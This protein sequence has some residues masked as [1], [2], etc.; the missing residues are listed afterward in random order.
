MPSRP[1][2]DRGYQYNLSRFRRLGYTVHIAV[3]LAPKAIEVSWKEMYHVSNTSKA[4]IDDCKEDLLEQY[5]SLTED[6]R[7]QKFPTTERAAE[8]TGMSR[9]T[10]QYWVEI[11]DIEAIFV[12]KNCRIRLD[13]LMTYLKSRVDGQK[14]HRAKSNKRR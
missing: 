5:L 14:H 2:D 13:S 3:I 7:E 8:L 12:G 10:I 4:I 11:E 6:Q 1:G 9:R